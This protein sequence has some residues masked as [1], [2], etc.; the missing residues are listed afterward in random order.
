MTEP[1]S[2]ADGPDLVPLHSDFDRLPDFL[3]PLVL[4]AAKSTIDPKRTLRRGINGSA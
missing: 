4:C 1:D 2:L 3:F